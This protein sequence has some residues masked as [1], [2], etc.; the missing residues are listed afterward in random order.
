MNAIKSKLKNLRLNYLCLL[1]GGF[2]VP[3]IWVL[4]DTGDVLP[5]LYLLHDIVFV[6][7]IGQHAP[8][9]VMS[10]TSS[11]VSSVV[12]VTLRMYLTNKKENH[13]IYL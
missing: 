8:K 9:P 3:V 7:V 13:W 5:D 4:E 11:H 2:V 12:F 10:K 6:L 1:F